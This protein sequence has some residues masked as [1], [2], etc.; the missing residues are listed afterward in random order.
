MSYWASSPVSGHVNWL[1]AEKAWLFFHTERGKKW[2]WH[3]SCLLKVF[4]N[5]LVDCPPESASQQ[6][7]LEAWWTTYCDMVG[8]PFNCILCSWPRLVRPDC[9]HTVWYFCQRPCNVSCKRVK[10]S[11]SREV[12]QK[13]LLPSPRHQQQFNEM[14]VLLITNYSP[15]VSNTITLFASLICSLDCSSIIQFSFIYCITIK[16]NCQTLMCKKPKFIMNFVFILFAHT[17]S[18]NKWV[19]VICHWHCKVHKDVLCNCCGI[20]DG[21]LII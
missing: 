16:C 1:W 20:L 19:G 7:Q 4:T 15:E 21:N 2:K 13:I 12:Y 18:I 11:L 14:C 10:Q 17:S 3:C 6:G 9:Y 5:R 8:D